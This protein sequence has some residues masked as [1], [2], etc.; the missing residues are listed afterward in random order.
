MTG[1]GFTELQEATLKVLG[2]FSEDIPLEPMSQDDL[3]HI[4]INYLNSVRYEQRN[5][6]YPFT[7]EV[8]DLITKYAQG[9]PRQL[10]LICE[11]VLRKAASNDEKIIDKKAFNFIW[12]TMQQE[13]THQLSPQLRHLLYVAYEAGGISEN[14]SDR[15][16][17]K[18]NALTFVEV[19]P[20]LKTMEEQGLVI[21]QE[22]EKGFRFSPS[23]LFEP[24]LIAEAESES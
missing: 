13:F 10:N 20:Q 1:R 17:D 2:I 24:K 18:L 16:L 12:Q 7:D 23:P 14:I 6:T 9:I 11:K 8:I 19:L 22:D 3:K 21:R 15:T 5:D 4:V